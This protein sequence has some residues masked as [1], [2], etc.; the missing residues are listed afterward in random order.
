MCDS[1]A[2]LGVYLNA[3]NQAK[4]CNSKV[5]NLRA[6]RRFTNRFTCVFLFH[7]IGLC[8]GLQKVFRGVGSKR[9]GRITKSQ[10]VGEEEMSESRGVGSHVFYKSQSLECS[11]L[12]P[13]VH[14]LG[15]SMPL[16][17]QPSYG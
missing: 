9:V 3:F 1:R 10:R 7:L 2:F 15:L 11:D 14:P 12:S 17:M 5:P 16:H 13:S 6:F 8:R 4:R